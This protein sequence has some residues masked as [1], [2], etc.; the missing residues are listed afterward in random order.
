MELSNI[1]AD[2][3][4][5]LEENILS[6]WSTVMVDNSHRGGFYGQQDGEGRIVED[7]P[8]GAILNAR[9]LWAFSAAY[10]VLRRDEYLVMATRARDYMLAHFVDAQYGGVYWSVDA[11]GNPLDTK[12]QTYAIGFAIYGFSEYARA[13]GDELSLSTAIQLYRDIEAHAF[14]PVNGGYHEALTRSWQ[15]IGDMRLSDKDENCDKTMNTHLHVIEPYTNLYRVWRDDGLRRQILALVDVFT[16]QLMNRQTGHLDLFFDTAWQGRRDIESFGHD[17]EA[18][19]LLDETA[20]V[21]DDAQL[22]ERLAPVVKR[23]ADASEEGLNDDGSL[24]GERWKSDG[25]TTTERDWW[26]QCECV[27][28]ELN[29][30]MR[31]G[32]DESKAYAN[33]ALRCYDYIKAHLVDYTNGEWYWGVAPDG[34]PNLRDDHAG[35]W[36]CPYHNTRM[37]LEVIER[38][39]RA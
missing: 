37:C 29:M 14:D 21:L 6:F 28:G 2:A 35:F 32:G 19:W 15:P 18:S 9:I 3:K 16:D 5:L 38:L 23:I 11:D 24:T 31:T 39:A 10:R 34:T 26:V 36:K 33:R 12:K 7:A 20:S 30:A 13:T 22:T 8:R 1:A 25:H 27:I 4:R 17:I